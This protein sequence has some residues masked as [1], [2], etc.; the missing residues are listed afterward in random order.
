MKILS[1]KIAKFTLFIWSFI[2]SHK[3]SSSRQIK[4]IDS[5]TASKKLEGREYSL[6]LDVRSEG[7]HKGEW[8]HI[9][10]SMLLPLQKLKQ[11]TGSLSQFKEKPILV[12][13]AIGGRSL[14]AAGLLI[15]AGFRRV[16]N[17]RGGMFRW[18]KEG[19]PVEMG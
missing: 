2:L 9:K 19:H 14:E 18:N 6:I 13:C 10:G 16:E 17:L 12:Y 8:G 1:K 15:Q 7:E 4:N 11:R 5:E 3:K